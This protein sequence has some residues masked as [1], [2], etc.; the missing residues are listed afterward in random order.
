MVP[1]LTN[2][3]TATTVHDLSDV[4][5]T[6]F[7]IIRAG[8]AGAALACFL[9]SY[10]LQ[11]IMISS[12]PGTANTPRAHITNM[13]ALEYLQDIGNDPRRKGNYKLFK[14]VLVRY[15]A[16]TS[17]KC[18]FDTALISFTNDIETSWITAIVVNRLLHKDVDGARS[19]VADLSYLVKNR[20]GNL[21]WVIWMGIVRMERVQ[22]FIG[23][24]TPAEI[25]NVS[26]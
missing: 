17:F 13:V 19:E 15:V 18:R 14:P 22:E 10:R 11:S 12:A 20:T 5:N 16:L 1:Y 8:P 23:D 26:M 6:E 24:D 9:G 3:G 2:E 21:H 7:L 4:V 25:L